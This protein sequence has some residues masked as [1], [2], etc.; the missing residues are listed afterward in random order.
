MISSELHPYRTA[1]LCPY[2]M[3]LCDPAWPD[4]QQLCYGGPVAAAR[5][6]RMDAPGTQDLLWNAPQILERFPM[7]PWSP[8]TYAWHLQLEGQTQDGRSQ[9]HGGGTLARVCYACRSRQGHASYRHVIFMIL[10][11]RSSTLKPTCQ[12]CDAPGLLGA[13]QQDL[14]DRAGTR[15]WTPPS[16]RPPVGEF[17]I[18]LTRC[19]RP[20]PTA[21]MP[22][23][24]PTSSMILSGHGSRPWSTAPPPPASMPSEMKRSH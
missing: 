11:L 6:H 2:F 15:T 23:A 16:T 7:P 9:E 10:N 17:L 5:R 21:P 18:P 14:W 13:R 3:Y 8:Q 12:H 4:V 1:S 19:H 24:P 22:K 20:P